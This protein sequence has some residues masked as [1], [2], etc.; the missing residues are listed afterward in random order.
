MNLYTYPVQSKDVKFNQTET[1]MVTAALTLR[2]QARNKWTLSVGQD[3]SSSASP[4][5]GGDTVTISDEAKAR[6]EG[7]SDQQAARATVD[8]G[9][10]AGAKTDEEESSSPAEQA[11]EK[12]LKRIK[13]L[14][15]EIQKAQGDS[16]LTEDE[17]NK[18]IQGLQ[19]EL[20]SLMNELQRQ[21]AGQEYTG[22]TPAQGMANSLT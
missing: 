20:M 6:A 15:Q 17:R 19:T 14:Q 12:V 5:G 16:T 8:T 21:S 11:K 22:G 1:T 9:L 7:S 13:E 4:D 10:A 3:G 18:R 2:A